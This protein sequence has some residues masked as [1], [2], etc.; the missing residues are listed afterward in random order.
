MEYFEGHFN[1]PLSL[2]P[3]DIETVHTDLTIDVTAPTIGDTRMA[4]RQIR[5]VK[6]AGRDSIPPI[7]LKLDIGVAVKMLLILFRKI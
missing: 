1:R 5:S 4:I 6:A 3:P 7:E 2:N